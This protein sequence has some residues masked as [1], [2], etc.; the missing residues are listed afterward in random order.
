MSLPILSRV[1]KYLLFE[2]SNTRNATSARSHDGFDRVF[3]RQWVHTSF[4]AL[5]LRV[6]RHLRACREYSQWFN[7]DIPANVAKDKKILV[8]SNAR[9]GCSKRSHHRFD[10][11]FRSQWVHT[12]FAALS[13]CVHRYLRACRGYSQGV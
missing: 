11:V 1:R 13:L 2:T 5:S 9:D 6:Y 8:T 7:H 4:A 10:H 3:R 12:S